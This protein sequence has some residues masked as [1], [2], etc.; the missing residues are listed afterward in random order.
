VNGPSGDAS[1]PDRPEP[2]P[3][4]PVQSGQGPRRPRRA[5]TDHLH[6]VH[7][8]LSTRDYLHAMWDR[9]D[10]TIEVPLEELRAAHRTTLLGNLWHLANPLLTIAVYYLVFGTLL[11]ASRP[12]DFLVWLTIGVFAFRTSQSTV[13]AGASSVS[14][15]AGL[16]RSIRFPRALLPISA[17][18][19]D[20]TTFAI[21][22][23]VIAVV[24]LLSGAG[25]SRRWLAVPV[26]VV[27]HSAINL[28][29]AFIAARLNESF[30]DIQEIIPFVFRLLQ[31]ASGVMIPIERLIPSDGST[32]WMSVLVSWNPILRIL[33]LYR[34]AF[35]G[36]PATPGHFAQ[37]ALAGVVLL[38]FGFRYFRAAEW[39]Y[40]RA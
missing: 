19:S 20:L 16:I 38:W 37:A 40:G 8:Q 35:L 7:Q 10:F 4:A 23:G 13:S 30:R 9:R 17:W 15:N 3:P 28:G 6:S 29:A 11:S 26:I 5:R 36:T 32:S 31:Y 34:W 22:L 39:R 21:N 18:I 1:Q 2:T 27:I 14:N 12:D 33:E 24:V 25:F